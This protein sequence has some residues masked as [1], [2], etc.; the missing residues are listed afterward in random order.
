MTNFWITDG[1]SPGW[2]V[3]LVVVPS[4]P[5]GSALGQYEL[6]VVKINSAK[7]NDPLQKNSLIKNFPDKK[8][9]DHKPNLL[10]WKKFDQAKKWPTLKKF[11][12]KNFKH[13]ELTCYFRWQIKP[14][15]LQK[16]TK[17]GAFWLFLT[18]KLNVQEGCFCTPVMHWLSTKSNVSHGQANE[19]FAD[20]WNTGKIVGIR[21][22][23][24]KLFD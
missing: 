23:K 11:S 2:R 1:G 13:P 22:L 5:R 20:F 4:I 10:F 24:L 15:W 17:I 6:T 12:T 18:T 8:L 14:N 16:W 21:T 19:L 7:K 9:T 3:V